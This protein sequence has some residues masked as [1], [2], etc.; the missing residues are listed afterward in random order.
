MRSYS[1]M[2]FVLLV[3]VSQQASAQSTD[4]LK[5]QLE[6]ITADRAAIVGIAV[7]GWNGDTLSIL[8]N[9]AFPMQSVFKYHIGVAMLSQIDKGK[10]KLSQK[11]VVE[12]KDMLPGLYSPLRDKH[13]QGGTFTIG[14]LIEYAITVSDNVACDVLLKLLGGP[15]TVETYFHSLG[16]KDIAIKIN[17]ELMQ[18]NWN[19]Q[20]QNWTTPK[21]AIDALQ[22]IYENKQLQ[23][24]KKNH[25][26]LWKVMRNTS[27]GKMRLKGQLPKGTVVAHKTGWSGKNKD[28]GITAAVNDIG[29]VFLN[30]KQYFYIS[31]FITDSREDNETN[32]LMIAEV[33]KAVWDYFDS[34]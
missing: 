32:E 19:L 4:S 10:F 25:R 24:S 7:K 22:L 17:E 2:L 27:T 12:E 15:Q 20:Y 1:I 13:P 31:V 11:V 9:H 6:R 3:L 18:A 14:E 5:K 8:G 28:L 29:I 23:L 30:K 33:C 16:V 21:A 34:Q 26:F